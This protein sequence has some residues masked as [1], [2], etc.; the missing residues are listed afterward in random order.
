MSTDIKII[1]TGSSLWFCK[2]S[3]SAYVSKLANG[4]NYFISKVNKQF[5]TEDYTEIKNG[6]YFLVS[7]VET[8]KELKYT[9]KVTLLR[10]KDRSLVTIRYKDLFHFCTN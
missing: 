3:N 8:I 5:L 9:T 7:G 1:K 6:E 4:R 10:E 2:K